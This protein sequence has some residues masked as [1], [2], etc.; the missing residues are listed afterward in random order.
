MKTG[1]G[2]IKGSRSGIYARKSGTGDLT[3]TTGAGT[4]T[5]GVYGIDAR[6][7]GQ[8][9]VVIETGAGMVTGNSVDGIFAYNTRFVAVG[10]NVTVTTGTGAVQGQRNGIRADN[11]GTGF[12][13]I[14]TT[15]DVTSN[16][17][18]AIYAL[19]SGAN[20]TDITVK[21]GPG[22][23]QGSTRGIDARNFGQGSIKITTGGG[24]TGNADE[25]I[26][27]RSVNAGD[28]GITVASTG[29][30]TSLGPHGDDFAVASTGASTTLIVSGTLKGG[31]GGAVEFD[32]TNA[33][34]DRLELR[35]GFQITTNGAA[36]AKNTVLA[37]D[38]TDTLAFGGTG[39]DTFDL[40][41]IDDG[42]NTKQFRSFETFRVE[43]GTWSFS[44]TTTEAFSQTGGTM[45]GTGTFGG[46][47]VTN[48]TLAPGNSI[49]TMTVNGN[50]TLGSGSIFEVEV[51]AAGQSDKVL[52]RSGGSVN[53]TGSVLRVMAQN[54]NYNP[55]TDYTIIDNDGADAVTGTFSS[56]T[57]N[58][59][60][61]TPSVN[62]KAGDGN[63]V[64]LTMVRKTTG[65]GGNTGGGTT[66]SGGTSGS[67]GTTGGSP[68]GGG[69]SSG[70]T[71]GGGTS[72]GAPTY[73]SF[74]SVA[75]TRNQCNVAHALDA[76]PTSNPLFGSVLTQT[77][78]GARQ[79]FNAL[80][81]EVHA[82]VAGTLVDDSRYVREAVLGRLMQAGHSGEALSASGPQMA[83]YDSG[84][85]MLGGADLYDGKSLVEV[86]ASAPLAF[87]T[88]AFGAWGD[89]DRNGNAASAGRDLGGFVSGMDAQL[90]GTWRVGVATGASFSNVSVDDR[91]SG[92]DVDSYH[93]GGYAGG[94]V[95]P[96]ALRGG[97]MWTW[98]EIETSRAVLFPNFYERQKADYDAGTG[99]IF[100]EIAYPTQVASIGVEPFAGLAYVSVDSDGIRERGGPQASLRGSS[101]DQ[102]VGYTTVGLRAAK[103]LSWGDTEITPHLSAAWLHAFDGVTP[104][105]SLAFATT[106]LGFEVTGVPLAQ[107]SALLDAGVDFA[108]SDK[109]SAG[110]SYSG[111]YADTVADNAVKGRLTWLFN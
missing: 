84:A 102:D 34:N 65:G 82:T 35:P 96:L 77:V 53:L 63:D 89:F 41:D 108:I 81:G 61:L 7:K 103:T 69:T 44:G 64:V 21:T 94:M 10:D 27:A 72:G 28:I 93:L 60:F 70:G 37:G 25:G 54:G 91:Y 98:N 32:Q 109:L 87:W 22:T 3:V 19:N 104:G 4:V 38:G 110:V 55:T 95:G 52:V 8:G 92:A 33:Y 67:G 23:V 58:F 11:W 106:G 75:Q 26:Y 24:V 100:G 68:S 45:K 73:V 30:V 2:T 31:G 43:S 57:S 59:A 83:T 74:C 47:T 88:R 78:A 85:M 101:F 71:S 97:G 40:G 16:A 105:A 12:I 15:G 66:G 99:Q 62:Y 1:S 46:L 14:A 39:E 17:S 42:T 50:F 5:G 76:F 9:S 56:V 79:A 36:G 90:F 51:N 80:S 29:T 107:D 18:A 20:S 86:P 48:G 6:N 111:Q 13:D 49:G